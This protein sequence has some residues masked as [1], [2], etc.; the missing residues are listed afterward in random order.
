M[1]FLQAIASVIL[2]GLAYPAFSAS[3]V[4]VMLR[5]VKASV[6][7]LDQFISTSPFYV[8]Y[9]S[10]IIV[11]CI[12]VI[13]NRLFY[14]FDKLRTSPGAARG[15]VFP[16][17]PIFRAILTYF[18]IYTGSTAMQSALQRSQKHGFMNKQKYTIISVKRLKIAIAFYGYSR[19]ILL[20]DK[21][22]K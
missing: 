18:R 10:D 12:I 15:A 16:L 2:E 4:F 19:I 6:I 13:V 17:R 3:V 7:I 22:R 14:F 21:T 20:Y 1:P 11:T 9:R 8:Y 5:S